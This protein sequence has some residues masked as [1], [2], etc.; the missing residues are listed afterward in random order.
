MTMMITV[1]RVMKF[2]K[3]VRTSDT[4]FT[5]CFSLLRKHALASLKIV[6]TVNA[7]KLFI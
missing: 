2:V 3:S 1:M 7:R 5:V 4:P 6:H